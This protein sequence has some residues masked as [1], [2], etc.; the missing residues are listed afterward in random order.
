[1]VKKIYFN[2]DIQDF[3][4]PSCQEVND[5]IKTEA[6]KFY[7]LYNSNRRNVVRN[8]ELKSSRCRYNED[9]LDDMFDDYRELY[10]NNKNDFDAYI[11]ENTILLSIHK[12]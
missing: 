6:R 8:E 7:D 2:I 5:S 11:N 1:M 12:V 3:E 4:T 10:H 9:D